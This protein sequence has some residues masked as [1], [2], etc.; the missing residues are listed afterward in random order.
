M[1]TENIQTL[2]LLASQAVLTRS[3]K[4]LVFSKPDAVLNAAAQRITG[5]LL[6]I[7]GETVVQLESILTKGKIAH[8]NLP[9]AQLAQRVMEFAA[10]YQQINLLTTVGD[11][12]LKRSRKGKITL[13]GAQKLSLAFDSGMVA[14]TAVPAHNREKQ[15]I[16]SGVEPFLQGLGI[17]DSTGRIHDK[18]QAKF[19]QINRFL[20]LIRD[21]EDKL[22][23][24]GA[25]HI[26]DLCCGKSYL[27]YAVYYYFTVI[28]G[29]RTVMTG[30]DLKEDVIFSC[31]ALAQK[32]GFTEL[33]F[34]CSDIQAYTPSEKPDMVISLHA[35][36]IATDIVLEQA[37]LWN[38][39]IILST[40]CCHHELNHHINC[41][42][43]HF[44]TDY[45]MLRQKF[46]DAATDAL[47]LSRLKARGYDC[48]ALELIDPEDTPKNIML[49][50][51]RR[52]AFDPASPE[53]ER[54]RQEFNQ[55]VDYVL[56]TG[57][58]LIGI[59]HI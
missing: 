33:Q 35:C 16:L 55:S 12:E 38:T 49:R 13:V 14:E 58:D 46:C 47:R 50:A 11:C 53:A 34:L 37:A 6:S 36:D 21:V 30:I 52:K 18:K 54:L 25:L 42:A 2:A 29:R 45:S 39:A 3:L 51:V 44:I 31:N 5:T 8:E 7:G 32:L 27:S 1:S 17:S 10:A 15:Y 26:C 23:A 4:K 9:A 22:P 43:L 19:R 59:H 40:P 48:E 20:E 24:E 56:G 41:K 28:R 57:V